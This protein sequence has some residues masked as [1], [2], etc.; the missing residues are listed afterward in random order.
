MAAVAFIVILTTLIVY[1]GACPP[2]DVMVQWRRLP[3]TAAPTITTEE[4]LQSLPWYIAPVMSGGLGNI[5][6][7]IAATTVLAD[8][9]AVACI[10]AWWDQT[11]LTNPTF[12]PFGGRGNPCDGI[13]LQHIFPNI[14]FVDFYPQYRNVYARSHRQKQLN[15]APFPKPLPSGFL[16]GWYLQP[17]FTYLLS[18]WML[19]L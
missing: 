2:D 9:Y 17:I 3:T 19:L 1:M 16:Q 8:R 14:H 13:T 11:N 12:R 18:I 5:I 4:Q 7:Q 6:F 10:V 15:F